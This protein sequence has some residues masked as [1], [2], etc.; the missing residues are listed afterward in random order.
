MVDFSKVNPECLRNV[1]AI[2]RQH[3]VTVN[4][5]FLS[6]TVLGETYSMNGQSA[7]IMGEII[8]AC[9]SEVKDMTLAS[10]NQLFVE[11]R[12]AGNQPAVNQTPATPPR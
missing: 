6:R 7:A 11:S 3:G 2:G 8:Q 10:L 4:N 1:A 5:D 12:K 9:G